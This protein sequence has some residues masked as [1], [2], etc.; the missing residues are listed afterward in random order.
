MENSEK[1]AGAAGSTKERVL[2]GLLAKR[3]GIIIL[4]L[5]VAYASN[6]FGYFDLFIIISL[7]KILYYGN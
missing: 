7:T 3:N 5:A 2:R 1:S 6:Y 4:F